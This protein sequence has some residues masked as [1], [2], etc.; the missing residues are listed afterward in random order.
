LG[1]GALT[2]SA[3]RD[4]DIAAL[5][6]GGRTNVAGFLLRLVAR[7]PFLFIAG[8]LYGPERL[9]T[10]ARAVL[11]AEAAALL[12]T[13]G[14]KRGLAQA[15]STTDRPHVHIVFD[16]LVVSLVAAIVT[17]GALLAFPD[18]MYHGSDST[19]IER[20]LPCVIFAGAWAD[21][22]LSAL[23]YRRNVK[24]AV[25]ARAVIE[26]WTISLAAGALFPFFP[27]DG[28]V[29]AYMLSLVV[30]LV[31][32]AAP[33]F[34]SYGWPLGWR[35][36]P[37]RIAALAKRNAPIAGA[38]AL[39][40][41]SRNIDRLII[42]L[43]FEPRIVGIYWTAQQ[44][45]TI[46]G[47]LKTSFDP[48]LGPVIT[49]ALTRDD[50]AAVARQ[51]RKVGFWIMAAQA[52]LALTLSI[53]GEAVMGTFGP[54]FV[55]GTAAMAFLLTAEA[56]ASTGAVAESALVYIV[57]LRNL[58]ISVAM[59]AF[60][61]VLS[62]GLIHLMLRFGWPDNYQAAAPA[63]ALLVSVALTSVIKASY[64][65]HLLKAPVS[66]WRWPMLGAIAAAVAVGTIF[67][68]LPHR[69]E[70]AELVIGIP[71]ISLAYWFVLWRWA[72]G[73]EDR[74][75]YKRVPS[76]EDATIPV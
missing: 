4:D 2:A 42:F 70:W 40:W 60:Q 54:K 33:F 67:T 66:G 14:L 58:M 43:M 45:A 50:R 47:K 34:G 13:F 55:S 72:F 62:L 23:A 35:P 11:F 17:S 65:S 16:C 1:R 53:P 56:A 9:G 69:Y 22:M 46:P 73:P 25:T 12:A 37:G 30:A 71:A 3:I 41:G 32:S 27:H 20:L 59:L 61:A 18:W 63:M 52:G 10:F 48:I 44:I 21:I 5:A 19:K 28:L 6:Q 49:E 36:H 7:L 64:L 24:A 8:R 76:P 26:P 38:E 39:E 68:A 31:S 29:I 75:L 57:R 74:A 15:L 51:V